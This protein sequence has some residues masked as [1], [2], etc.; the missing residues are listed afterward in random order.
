MSL[1]ACAALVERGDPDR[2][3]VAMAAPPPA[4]EILFPLYAFNLEI[5]RAPW[6]TREPMLAEMR[7]QWWRDQVAACAA[8]MLPPPHEVLTPLGQLLRESRLDPAPLDALI[9]T[10][11]RDIEA[12]PFLADDLRTYLEGTA[13]NLLWAGAKALGSPE[14]TRPAALQAGFASG[15]ASWLLALPELSARN[16]GLADETP[17]TI[18]ALATD[19]LAALAKARRTRFGPGTPALRAAT[20]AAPVL[21]AARHDPDAALQGRLAPPEGPKRLRLLWATLRGGW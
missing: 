17:A 5:A 15:L 3:R 4:R 14:P 1:E 8:G 21:R 11:R 19:A 18:R 2:F 10:R 16:R 6:A 20:L 12:E 7:L 9:E 13:G